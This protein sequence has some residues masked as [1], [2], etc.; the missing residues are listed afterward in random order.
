MV[1]RLTALT[2]GSIAFTAST[3]AA[4]VFL[5]PPVSWIVIVR[6]VSLSVTL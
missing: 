1:S 3:P 2:M 5:V 4:T 6:K